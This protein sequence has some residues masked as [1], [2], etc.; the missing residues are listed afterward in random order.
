MRSGTFRHFDGAVQYLTADE[1]LARRDSD[2]SMPYKSSQ[3]VKPMS[4]KV[5]KLN[6]SINPDD[7]VELSSHFF[8][9]NPL[10]FE[11][12]NGEYPEHIVNILEKLR[13]LSAE[14]R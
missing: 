12:F 2:F 8:A 5:F 4:K 13:A 9:A 10:M 11:Y 6:G 3:H 1:Y 7:W 14:G